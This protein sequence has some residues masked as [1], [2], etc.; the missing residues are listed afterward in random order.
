M[1]WT[2]PVLVISDLQIPFENSKAL[3]FFKYLKRH[4]NIPDENVLNVGDETDCYHG[5]AWPKDPD[6]KYSAVGELAIAKEKLKEWAVAFPLMKLAISNHGMRWV[7]KAMAAEIPSQLLRSYQEIFETPEGWQWK[8]EWRFTDCKYPFRMVHGMGYSG[9]AGARNA[10]TSAG[11]STLIG[12]LHANAGISYILP[13]GKE[14]MIWGFN[15][16]CCIDPEQYAFE[17][18]RHNKVKPC[19]GGGIVYNGGKTPIWIPL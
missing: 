18:E 5:G 8:H 7:R 13:E 3:E 11:I 19:L 15:V 10:A 4:H 16:G 6:G 2:K 9:V 14:Q 17:Y 12:H 1:D